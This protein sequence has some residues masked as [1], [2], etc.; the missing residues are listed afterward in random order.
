M[1]TSY[2]PRDFVIE[3]RRVFQILGR[4][5]IR[6]LNEFKVVLNV[7]LAKLILA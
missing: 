3:N 4:W 5:L 6:I 7:I 2:S 1:F